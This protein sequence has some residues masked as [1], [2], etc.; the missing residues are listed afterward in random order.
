MLRVAVNNTYACQLLC[1]CGKQPLLVQ[2]NMVL[3]CTKSNKQPRGL[4]HTHVACASE[5]CLHLRQGASSL[6]V[7]VAVVVAVFVVATCRCNTVLRQLVAQTQQLPLQLLVVEGQPCCMCMCA[8]MPIYLRSGQHTR[9][10]RMPLLLVA[11]FC[12]QYTD[13]CCV[14][15]AERVWKGKSVSIS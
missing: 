6:L 1:Q 5:P 4:E 11:A 10:H 12:G 14:A 8:R 2:S 15:L 9:R 3:L 7:G 13:I